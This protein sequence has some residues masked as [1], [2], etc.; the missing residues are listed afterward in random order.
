M[1]YYAIRT[2]FQERGSPHVHLFIWIFN[3]PNIQ[4]EVDYIGFIEKTINTQLP[5]HSNDPELFELVKIYQVHAYRIF[6]NKR[7]L[8]FKRP[9]PI[10]AQYN[11]KN[12]P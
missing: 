3:A 10:N 5:D 4:N 6:S 12:I 1:K 11:P 2:E 7:P 9:S 8:S